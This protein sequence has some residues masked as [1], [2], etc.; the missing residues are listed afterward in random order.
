MGWPCCILQRAISNPEK[1]HKKL[2]VTF[3]GT[4]EIG[5]DCGSL[6]KEFFKAGLSLTNKKL[7]ERESFKRVPKKDLS[8]EKLLGC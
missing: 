2:V 7:F 6:R 4:G 8:L 3:V 1:L 5:S